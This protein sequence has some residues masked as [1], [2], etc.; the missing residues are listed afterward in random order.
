MKLHA[1]Q[2]FRGLVIDRDTGNPVR[3]VL[4]VD[5]EAGLLEAYQV[6]GRG[7]IR[8][9]AEGNLLT[10]TARGRFRWV[11]GEGG[12]APAAVL[13]AGA[14]ACTRCQSPL[15]LP[16]DDLCVACRARDGRAG[17]L[18]EGLAD[19]AP[20]LDPLAAHACAHPGCNRQGVYAV[21]DEVTASPVEAL[22]LRGPFRFRR[23]ACVGRRWYCPWHWRAP[24]LLDAKGEVV[25]DQG[26]GFGVR[27]A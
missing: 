24:R 17:R 4:W 13:P 6:D 25:E 2:G 18:L 23:G 19:L 8:K 7:D 20:G 16:G 5:L 15:T 14:P 22:T 26:H 27:P 11:P 3:K 10:Y 21:G 12:R 1:A 9:D